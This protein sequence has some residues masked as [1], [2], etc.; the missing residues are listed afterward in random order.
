M[1]G[2]SYI[3]RYIF[4]ADRFEDKAGKRPASRTRGQ[5]RARGRQQSQRRT[6]SAVNAQKSVT[7]SSGSRYRRRADREPNYGIIIGSAVA[8]VIL[9]GGI[10]FA[11]KGGF[12]KSSDSLIEETTYAVEETL[13][14]NSIHEDVYLDI[15][16]F[17]AGAQ[18]LNINGMNQQQVKEAIKAQYTWNLVVNNTNPMLSV[19]SMPELSM[20]ETSSETAAEAEIQA[21]N[22]GSEQTVEVENPYSSISIRPEASSFSVPDLIEVNLDE[23]IAQIFEDH[24]SRESQE[25]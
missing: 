10:I 19:F 14:P 7:R 12:G 24:K 4:M 17:A 15:S 22:D 8:A 3:W 25:T 23:M 11:L 18:L 6:A 13:D 1:Q 2:V 9:V 21:D 5:S 20:G 16:S